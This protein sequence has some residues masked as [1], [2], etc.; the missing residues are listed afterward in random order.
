MRDI[1][2]VVTT[3]PRV[4]SYLDA[5]LASIAAAGFADVAV[6]TDNDNSGT[7]LPYLTAMKMALQRRVSA[8]HVLVFQ[9][10]IRCAEGLAAVAKDYRL[11]QGNKLLSYYCCSS[12]GKPNSDG[13][14]K[15]DLQLNGTTVYGALALMWSRDIAQR[16]VDTFR[17]TS[18]TKIDMQI[19]DWCVKHGVEFWAHYPSLVQHVGRA[20]TLT[21]WPKP[22]DD[23]RELIPAR[24]ADSF[25]EKYP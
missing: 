25:V 6:S 4:V 9:D 3:A 23:L 18:R 24:M 2:V 14:R 5:T 8:S 22:T 1:S 17:A 16:F 21:A 13:Y 20:S 11:P 12:Y 7:A 19:G 15:I 10:D